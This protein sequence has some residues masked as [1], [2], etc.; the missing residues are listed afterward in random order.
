MGVLVI[1]IQNIV[2]YFGSVRVVICF[3]ILY[4]HIAEKFCAIMVLVH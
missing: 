1:N 3:I 2:V 4:F